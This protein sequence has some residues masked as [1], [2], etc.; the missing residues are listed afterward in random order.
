MEEITKLV[1]LTYLLSYLN[2][3][4]R[5][6]SWSCE[7]GQDTR[8]TTYSKGQINKLIQNDRAKQWTEWLEFKNMELTNY[9]NISEWIDQQGQK[10]LELY[11][12]ILLQLL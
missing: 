7:N 10:A 8:K 1:I 5:Q 2:T 6:T 12:K 3:K 9:Q 11:L 4:A